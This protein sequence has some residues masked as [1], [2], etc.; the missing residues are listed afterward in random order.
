MDTAL[1]I[2]IYAVTHPVLKYFIKY[3]WILNSD[4]VINLG[5]KL[6]PVG[7]IDFILNLSSPITYSTDKATKSI[8]G[9]HFNGIKDYCCTIEQSGIL[10]VLGI[11]FYPTGL[12]PFAKVPLSEFS[13]NTIEL[14]QLFNEFNNDMKEK[15]MAANSD[16]EKINILENTLLKILDHRLIPPKRLFHLCN[17]FDTL[18]DGMNITAFCNKY[19]I[20]QRKL[21]R[22]FNKYVGISPKSYHT[23]RRFQNVLHHLLTMDYEDLTTI[24]HHY[25]YYDQTH[26]IKDFKSFAGCP[27]SQFLIEKRS[28][29]EI[30]LVS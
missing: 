16:N 1:P 10:H 5:H 28:V 11:S 30:L 17:T 27:P 8:A 23:L 14:D 18:H 13:G 3:Y 15:L 24:A 7:N 9:F 21:Q 6:L 22:I 25:D 26:F 12:Y 20:H 2:K 29:K 4:R 19:G